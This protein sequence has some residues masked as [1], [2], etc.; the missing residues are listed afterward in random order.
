MLSI[1]SPVSGAGRPVRRGYPGGGASG[2]LRSGLSD[3]CHAESRI[4]CDLHG[5]AA[6]RRPNSGRPRGGRPVL[7]PDGSGAGRRFSSLVCSASERADAGP[8]AAVAARQVEGGSAVTGARAFGYSPPPVSRSPSTCSASSWPVA[9]TVAAP[10][11]GSPLARSFPVRPGCG[12]AVGGG[13]V[14]RS[15]VFVMTGA[16]MV[17]E[18]LSAGW[19][20]AP[21]GDVTAAG[22]RSSGTWRR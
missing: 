17:G 22:D 10:R 21:R 4:C 6:G 20:A 3:G 12:Q 9:A 19:T 16:V 8:G 11:P 1:A 2:L 7:L 13:I 5:P 15:R 14:R 18:R